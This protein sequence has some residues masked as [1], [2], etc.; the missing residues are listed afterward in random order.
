MMSG[1]TSSILHLDHDDSSSC[2][3]H[4]DD[5]MMMF[6]EKQAAA[7]TS[8]TKTASALMVAASEKAGMEHIDR[9]RI[10]AILLRES[11]NSSFMERQRNMDANTN[12]RIVEMK[13]RLA[14]KDNVAMNSNWRTE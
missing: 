8:S 14:E 2:S 3:S 6:Q 13:Q 10:N 11:G 9:D 12:K 7:A 1:T 5:N 4:E